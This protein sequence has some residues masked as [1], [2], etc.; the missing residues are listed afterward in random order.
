MEILDTFNYKKVEFF[1][2]NPEVRNYNTEEALSSAEIKDYD[3][4]EI[5]LDILKQRDYP[6]SYNNV[7]KIY[8]Q[9][10]NDKVKNKEKNYE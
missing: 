10:L 9:K 3:I 2:Y 1:T 6:E 8:F 7:M 5:F 4:Q